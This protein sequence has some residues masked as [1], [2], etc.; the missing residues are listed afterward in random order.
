MSNTYE[1]IIKE[2]AKSL[3]SL[4]VQLYSFLLVTFGFLFSSNTLMENNDLYWV[5][6]GLAITILMWTVSLIYFLS[7]EYSYLEK[8]SPNDLFNN[9]RFGYVIFGIGLAVLVGSLLYFAFYIA[10]TF[11]LPVQLSGFSQFDSI[12]VLFI[13]LFIG[14]TYFV[15]I[16]I[17]RPPDSK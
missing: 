1:Q 15:L 12:T 14:V 5:T 11:Q 6:A 7:V 13:T 9:T 3:K 4:N 8:K 2:L 17:P 10:F 16:R